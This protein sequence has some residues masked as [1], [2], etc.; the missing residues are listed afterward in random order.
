MNASNYF[1]MKLINK[2]FFNTTTLLIKEYYDIE[3][4]TGENK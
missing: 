1:F 4:G 2:D 3:V